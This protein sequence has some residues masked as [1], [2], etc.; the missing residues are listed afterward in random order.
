MVWFIKSN[1]V[2]RL[3]YATSMTV[4]DTVNRLLVFFYS[5]SMVI[6]NIEF[7]VTLC[8]RYSLSEPYIFG[9]D[10]CSDTDVKIKKR[11]GLWTLLMFL[12]LFLYIQINDDFLHNFRLR[13]GYN[14]EG[15]RTEIFAHRGNSYMAPEN[16]LAAL[17]SAIE[18]GAD[19]AEIDVRMTK[20]GELI[21]LHDRSLLRT[22]G[23]DIRI[24]Q[25]NYSQL[26][27][28][29]VGSW[30]SPDF[31]GEKIPTLKEALELS[32][33]ELTLM[34][35]VKS[36]SYDDIEIVRRVV[37]NVEEMGLDQDVIIASFNLGVLKEVKS[38]NSSIA[39]CLI[40]RFAYGDVNEI[41]Y[42]DMFSVESKFIQ[43]KVFQTIS[44]GSKALAVWTVN[45][46]KQIASLR[47]MGIDAII[48][49]RPV[50]A[51]EILY[52]DTVPGFLV[53]LISSMLK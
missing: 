29:D 47:D 33:D 17:K 36:E 1:V 40:L 45:E 10:I 37:E 22:G 5:I 14:P 7:S 25:L 32:K 23:I 15:R 53:D 12:A 49:D 39:T 42:V 11:R 50:T 9:D 18:E 44:N 21:L 13:T 6:I 51:R 31:K 52:E 27:G 19:G 3:Q 16:T 41:E 48:T 28:I 20:D 26:E 4:M 2:V 34:I 8:K 46:G 43:R 30:F 24:D 35:E 38:L